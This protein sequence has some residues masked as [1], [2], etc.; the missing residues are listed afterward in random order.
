MKTPTFRTDR[1]CQ[2]RAKKL[3]AQPIWSQHASAT[4]V[5]TK[6]LRQKGY[7]RITYVAV[8]SVLLIFRLLHRLRRQRKPRLRGVPRAASSRNT[9][10]PPYRR[11]L[12]LPVAPCKACERCACQV[13]ILQQLGSNCVERGKGKR[14]LLRRRICLDQVF[15][16]KRTRYRRR[17]LQ[18]AFTSSIPPDCSRS[19]CTRHLY[20]CTAVIGYASSPDPRSYSTSPWRTFATFNI[21][22]TTSGGVGT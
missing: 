5:K 17:A 8:S 16:A 4:Q 2:A 20:F 3:V 1:S 9:R 22:S 19:R 12:R 14:P 6:C 15:V 10:S 7:L 18:I 21:A 11:A 13:S